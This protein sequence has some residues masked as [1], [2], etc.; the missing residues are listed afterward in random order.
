MISASHLYFIIELSILSDPTETNLLCTLYW[1]ALTNFVNE[2]SKSQHG[3]SP[4][5]MLAQL[6]DMRNSVLCWI[7]SHG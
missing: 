3:S 2:C 5:M 7:G 1:V 4:S 6:Q